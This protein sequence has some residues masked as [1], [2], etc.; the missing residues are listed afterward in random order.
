MRKTHSGEK[1]AE[2]TLKTGY[3]GNRLITIHLH[4]KVVKGYLRKLSNRTLDFNIAVF[5]GG[6]SEKKK[7]KK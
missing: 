5:Y 2:R 7:E 3:A 6:T 4:K 1:L